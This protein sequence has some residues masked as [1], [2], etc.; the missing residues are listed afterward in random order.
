M[1][2][3]KSDRSQ[4]N[5]QE[6]FE[7]EAL[8]HLDSLFHV[9]MWMVRERTEAEDLVQD[10]F[11]QALRSFHRFTPGTNC[12]AWLITILYN[13]RLKKWRSRGKWQFAG[14]TDEEIANT[15]AYEAPTP[16]NITDEDV[17][18]AVSRIPDHYQEII[19]LSDVENLSYKEIAEALKVP[20][21][22]VM[23]RLFRGRKLLRAELTAYA[24]AYGIGR[25]TAG[26]TRTPCS[27]N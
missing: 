5:L 17:L 2:N 1:S 18:Q 27:A 6:V 7:M 13:T 4:E 22:T 8:P 19:L 25:T 26:K 9:A 24:N 3:E 10:T 12:R 21:G 20:I 14:T 23:S 16:Q 15:I 11:M